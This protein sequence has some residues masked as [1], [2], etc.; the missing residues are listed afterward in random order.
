MISGHVFIATSIDG[1]IA[2]DDGDIGWLLQRDDPSEDHGYDAFI[3]T[4]DVILMGRGSYE[5][6]RDVKPWPYTR[7]VLVLSAT[8]EGQQ[9]PPELEG[10]VRFF[11]K[12]PE[13]AMA[14]LEAEGC[15]RVY[16]DGGLIIQSFLRAGLISDMVIT[17]VPVLLGQGRSLFGQ[18]P[19]DIPLV[20]EDTR[21]FASGLV[22][23]RYRIA[24]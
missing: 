12:S 22:Q 24:S 13:Q 19:S 11:G 6:I 9:T 2:R 8:L 15:R 14:M 3:E 16:V 5:S 4:I 7:P 20:H 1:F 23:S 21:A 17:H 10:R 18:I